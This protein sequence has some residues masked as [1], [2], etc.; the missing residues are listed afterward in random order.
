MIITIRGRQTNQFLILL[1]KK[2]RAQLDI[3]SLAHLSSNVISE[4]L[5]NELLFE[6]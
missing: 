5:L 6:I 4:C 3:L 2:V 1:L